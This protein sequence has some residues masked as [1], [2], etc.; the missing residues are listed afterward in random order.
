MTEERKSQ[1][2]STPVDIDDAVAAGK[3]V[4]KERAHFRALLLSNPNYF[5]NLPVSEFTPAAPIQSN[6]TYEEIGCVGFQPQAKRLDAVVFVNE[7]SGYGGGICTG[8][9]Q[10]HVRFYVSFD[11][12]VSWVDQGYSSFAVYDVPQGTA[13][14][15]RLEYA[16]SVPCNPKKKLCFVP[17]TLVARA[18][19]SWNQIP[20][21]DQPDF[22]PVWGEVHNTHIQV[23]PRMIFDWLDLVDDFKLKLPPQ[24]AQLV[25]FS[26]PVKLKEPQTLSVA[27]L[28]AAYKG[29]GVEP[30]RYAL[31]A[32]QKLLA[33]P[34]AA[35]D[36]GPA[37]AA[38]IFGNLGINLGDL[39]GPILSPGDGSTFYEEM[40]CVG[41]NPG[42]SELVAVLRIK[43]PN[44]YSGG[45][46]TAGSLEYV[47]FWADLNNNGTFET[48]LGTASV[49]VHDIQ[50]I[51]GKGL[52]YS[53]YL[54]VNFGVYRRPCEQ[55]PR[56]IPI[57]AILSWAS[58]PDCAFPNK[59]PVWGNR[60]NTLILLPPG[61]PTVPGDF[62]PVLF[63]ISSVA[64]CNI[65]Q[66]TG[67]A[68]GDRPFGA[69]VYIIG[70]IPAADIVSTADR[71]KYR[72]FYR[73]VGSPSWQP[74]AND[75]TVT[76]DQQSGPGTLV[77]LPLTQQVDPSGPY[78]G[79]YTYREYGIGSGTWRRIAAPYMGLLGVWHTTQPMAG[80]WEI[81]IEALDTVGGTTYFADT[82]HCLDGVNR[83]IVIVKLDEFRPVPAIDIT[84]FSTDGGVTWQAA[85]ACGEFAPG[86]WIKGTYS[87][88]DEHFRILSLIVEP[89]GPAGGATPSPSLRSYPM[90]PTGGEA[91]TWTLDTSPMQP[92]GYVVRLDVYDR[93]IVGG[94]HH[95]WHDFASVGFCLRAETP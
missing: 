91:G 4:P 62:R 89:S 82:T 70:D 76:V 69:A 46:C 41:F 75:F 67:L 78:A 68:P 22:A 95:G 43:R 74:L 60:E 32:V 90:V 27:E 63:N 16:V 21:A 45:P 57:R 28:H 10:E 93:T 52:E 64:V 37:P 25:D 38:S 81:R 73:Q 56:L 17:N 65:D 71:F 24:F 12:G 11:N 84:H 47:T 30:H 34:A 86:V 15:K 20:P 18:I 8:G 48:C 88:T 1:D 50:D 13:G 59:S 6:K 40:E 9:S 66:A 83:E 19:L 58:V 79:C 5:G 39:I 77:Q 42:S 29:K 72:L 55:G 3:P 87:V 31:P 14:A 92:C 53:A 85:L 7:P 61:K 94:D 26:E 51:P 44:G 2:T 54:P 36:L 33:Q 35:T 80:K 49:R 23:D